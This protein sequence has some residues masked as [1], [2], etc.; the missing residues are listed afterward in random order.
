MNLTRLSQPPL[1]DAPRTAFGRLRARL[2]QGAACENGTASLEF[3]LVIPLLLMVFMASFESG[4]LMT[5][6]LMLEQAV[7]ITMRNL[8]IGAYPNPTH[9][10]IKQEICD[11]TVI[12]K[13]CSA[14]IRVELTSVNT[15]SWALPSGSTTCVDRSR[16]VQPSLNFNPGNA[17]EVMLVRV[18]VIQ[19]SIFPTA[20][21]GLS[22]ERE[23]GGGY[24][25]ISISAFVNEP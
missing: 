6:H 22:L 9:D 23:N 21:I 4:L 17:S 10:L 1:A 2:K 24:G 20:G 18:C 16:D 25:L 8:R 19:D 7:D 11:R 14:N 3:V 5:R 13:D 15:S 12:L